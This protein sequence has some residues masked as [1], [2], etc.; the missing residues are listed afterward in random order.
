MKAISNYF[1]CDLCL[2]KVKIEGSAKQIAFDEKHNRLTVLGYD[3]VL[4]YFNIPKEQ[5]RY[6]DE[7][8]VRVF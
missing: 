4:Y 2:A 3:R 8:E 5:T 1:D 6:I 7:V